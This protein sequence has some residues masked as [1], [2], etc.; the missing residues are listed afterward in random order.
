MLDIIDPVLFITD[1]DAAIASAVA[2]SMPNAMHILCTWH[3]ICQNG[4]YHLRKFLSTTNLD[5][6]LGMLW[7]ICLKEDD[8]D[9][10]KLLV[11]TSSN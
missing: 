11:E 9:E 2:E 4:T 7:S 5:V 6:V 3:I 10:E 8:L 1:G